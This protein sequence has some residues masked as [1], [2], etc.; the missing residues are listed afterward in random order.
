[1]KNIDRRNFYLS[2]LVGIIG[3]VMILVPALGWVD[4]YDGGGAL[5]MLG[6]LLAITGPIVSFLFRRRAQ[7]FE[8]LQQKDHQLVDWQYTQAE[9]QRFVE[10][11]KDFRQDNKRG[12]QL[13]ILVFSLLFGGLFWWFDREAG[14]IVLLTMIGLNIFIALVAWLSQTYLQSWQELSQPECVI[15][16]DGLIIAGQLHVWR[17]W[18]AKLEEV[19]LKMGRVNQLAIT[20]STPSRYSRQFYTINVPVPT[21][22]EKLAKKIA[23]KLAK[24]I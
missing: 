1:M 4:I 15:G 24:S 11:E 19:E 8:R 5:I 17:S 7:V 23:E 21:G 2:W 13:T 18:G 22:E 14:G 3:V 6:I 12:I 9:W 16:W 20:Y 10:T